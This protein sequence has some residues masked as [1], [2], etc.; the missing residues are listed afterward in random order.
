MRLYRVYAHLD[1]AAVGA[2]GHAG[3]IYPRQ[4][5]GR[6]DNS[7]DYLL[8]YAAATPD[9]AVGESFGR[10][11]EW[12]NDM[13]QV[14]YLPG[15]RSAIATFEL[16]DAKQLINLD[17]AGNLVARGLRPTQVVIR[18]LA[19]TQPLAR[20]LF[21]ETNAD[22]NRRWAGIRWW[23]FWAP[24]W[25]VFALWVPPGEVSPLRLLDVEE[26]TVSHPAVQRAATTIVRSFV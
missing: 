13:F 5:S 23:S 20:S 24:Q 2:P 15:A 4:V 18:D 26:L 11:P 1:G 3:Y 7:A 6:W 12:S 21:R 9:G 19:F 17:D 25:P 16:D 8:V 22:G 10:I 14:P